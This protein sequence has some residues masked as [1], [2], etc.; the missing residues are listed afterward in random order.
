[1]PNRARGQPSLTLIDY[2]HPWQVELARDYVENEVRLLVADWMLYRIPP[3][4]GARRQVPD[5]AKLRF[6]F[7]TQQQAEAFKA[8]LGGVLHEVPQRG[9]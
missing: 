7:T 1:M 8:Q 3:G 5:R 9:R 2:Q 4:Q 6:A